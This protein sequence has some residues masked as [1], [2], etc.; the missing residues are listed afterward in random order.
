MRA[1]IRSQRSRLVKWTSVG[2]G[3]ATAAYAGWVGAAWFRYGRPGRAPAGPRDRLLDEFMPAYDVAERHFAYVAA[4]PDVTL[5]AA[6]E[7]D[8]N[9]SLLMR[10]IFQARS[11]ILGARADE[12][13]RPSGLLALT[14]SLGWGVLAELPGREIV[15]GAVT[16][17]WTPDVVFRA[18]P[19]DTFRDFRDP[20]FVKIVWT[21]RADPADAGHTVFRTETRAVATDAAARARF[22]WYWARFSPGIIL[23]RR[24]ML[25]QLRKEAERLATT[26]VAGT[27]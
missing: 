12:T 15:M 3:L 18:L 4:P 25:I 13:P 1:A 9:A 14:K 23:I 6:E 22:R 11:A 10:A 27:T 8:L 16:Q 19:P 26:A 20:G 17:P 2:L 7:A 24:L 21:L 5:L